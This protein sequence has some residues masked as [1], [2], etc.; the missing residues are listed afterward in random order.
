[1][2]GESRAFFVGVGGIILVDVNQPDGDYN[3]TF[4]VAASYE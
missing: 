2:Q 1:V 4:A 3:G